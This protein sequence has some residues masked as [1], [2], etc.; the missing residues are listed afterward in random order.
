ML[1]HHP[2]LIVLT[3]VILFISAALIWEAVA[4]GIP[5]C[6]RLLA[7]AR[8]AQEDPCPVASVDPFSWLSGRLRRFYQL[9]AYMV[10]W[11][12]RPDPDIWDDDGPSQDFTEVPADPATAH[13]TARAPVPETALAAT[14]NDP[15]T[16]LDQIELDLRV[17]LDKLADLRDAMDAPT[18]PLPAVPMPAQRG[19][20]LGSRRKRAPIKASAHKL[21]ARRRVRE[22][23][24]A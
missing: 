24:S 17:A 7:Q 10:S 3:P 1:D 2:I 4:H 9:S 12:F 18:Q 20:Q 13:W 16:V 8:D 23:S 19:D 5:Y 6:R 14:A 21:P 15:A 22:R 11:T